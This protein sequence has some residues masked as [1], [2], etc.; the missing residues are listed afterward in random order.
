MSVRAIAGAGLVAAL[1]F[2]G[3]AEAACERFKPA[4][5]AAETP[6]AFDGP[7]SFGALHGTVTLDCL[8][9]AGSISQGGVEHVLIRDETGVIHRLKTGDYM[10]ENAGVIS[11]ID[12]SHI[13]I[14]QL[15]KQ[16]GELR[17]VMVKFPKKP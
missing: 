11:S 3:A 10:G 6:P 4:A 8:R 9:Y 15:V 12:A 13:H 1:L 14:E 2:A 16:G 17:S 7:G 5:R